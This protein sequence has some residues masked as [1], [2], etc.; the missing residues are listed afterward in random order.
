MIIKWKWHIKLLKNYQNCKHYNVVKVIY[1][2]NS[3]QVESVL[4]QIYIYI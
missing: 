2:F 4:Q 1:C 3:F